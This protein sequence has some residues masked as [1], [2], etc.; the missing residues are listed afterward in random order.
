MPGLNDGR[1][2]PNAVYGCGH[3]SPIGYCG[4]KSCRDEQNAQS[5][6]AR[7]LVVAILIVQNFCRALCSS[8]G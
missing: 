1:T 3:L 4:Q 6:Q 8:P 7:Q 5:R 2:Y